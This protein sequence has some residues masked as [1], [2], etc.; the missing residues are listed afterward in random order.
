MN[1]PTIRK[2]LYYGGNVLG[3][4]GGLLLIGSVVAWMVGPE[5]LSD[6]YERT[7]PLVPF[8][9]AGVGLSVLGTL[10]VALGHEPGATGTRTAVDGKI[11]CGK[12]AA[13]NDA[14]AKFC[15]Q[16]GSPV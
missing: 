6:L 4:I 10:L 16:C 14:H 5:I 15:N 9:L 3:G 11:R 1:F 7:K 8:L 13:L 12:C 2:V